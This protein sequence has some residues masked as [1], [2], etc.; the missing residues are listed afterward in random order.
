MTEAELAALD[1]VLRAVE[2][3]SA[4]C[5]GAISREIANLKAE[6]ATGLSKRDRQRASSPHV[7]RMPATGRFPAQA[8]AMYDGTVVD[9]E[10]CFATG[11]GWVLDAVAAELARPPA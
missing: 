10:A 5:T 6:R 11:L 7:R 9:A 4:Y 1:T 8:K 3:V 2:T